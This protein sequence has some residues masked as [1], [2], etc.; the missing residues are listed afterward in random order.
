M[1]NFDPTRRTTL[2]VLALLGAGTTGNAGVAVA[3]EH[4]T[5]DRE[6]D[7]RDDGQSDFSGLFV[8]P[9]EPEEGSETNARGIAVVQERQD[10]L[11]FVVEVEN[12]ENAFMGHIHEDEVLGPIAVW[13]YDFKTQA[14]RLEEGEFTGLLDVG[15]I[16]DEAIATG[17]V[18]EAQSETV[19]ELLE[20]IN[21]GEAYV[22]IHTEENPGGEISGRLEP[23]DP[24]AI[25]LST[26]TDDDSEPAADEES[27]DGS[28]ADPDTDTD[29]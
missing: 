17:R 10:G 7:Q 21:A 22:N 24:S 14:E 28:E 4:Q 3:D 27:T 26:D 29:Y 13:L 19:E 23:F 2:K 1:Q 16:T 6:D 25:E 11:K 8:A 12:I 20:K 18:P 9:L 15:T 5:E